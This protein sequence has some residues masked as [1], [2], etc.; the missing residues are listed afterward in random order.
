MPGPQY[1]QPSKGST[2]SRGSSSLTTSRVLS[3]AR[4]SHVRLGIEAP[5]YSSQDRSWASIALEITNTGVLRGRPQ[6]RRL[7]GGRHSLGKVGN[8]VLIHGRPCA[9]NQGESGSRPFSSA[10]G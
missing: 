9:A 2:R 7:V 1:P 10:V 3:K 4:S 5:P 6:Q 8:M